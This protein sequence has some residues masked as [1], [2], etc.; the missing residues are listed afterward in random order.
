M[1]VASKPCDQPMADL[2]SNTVAS[3]SANVNCHSVCPS[4][5][6][7]RKNIVH[8]ITLNAPPDMTDEHK[9][10]PDSQPNSG[11]VT[12]CSCA[13]WSCTGQLQRR[14]VSRAD[15]I[16]QGLRAG[17][18]LAGKFRV[19][20]VIGRGGMG[21]IFAAHHMHLDQRVAIKVL[22]PNA[23]RNQEDIKHFFTEAQAAAKIK[24]ERAARV[25][26]LTVLDC[27]L[28]FLVMEYL[29]GCDLANWLVQKGPLPLALAVEFV[30]QAC[31]AIAEAHIAGIVHRDLKPGNMFCSQRPDGSW[32]IKVIDFGIAK[33]GPMSES[34]PCSHAMQHDSV[35]GSPHYMSPEQL[36]SPAE[37]DARADIW[38]LGVTLCE[39]LTGRLP[40]EGGALP[41]LAVNIATQPTPDMQEYRADIMSAIQPVIGRCLQKDPQLRYANVAELANALAPFAPNRAHLS[42]ERIRGSVFHGVATT[43]F[44]MPPIR[45]SV[46]KSTIR[47]RV[48]ASWCHAKRLTAGHQWASVAIILVLAAL[49]IALLNGRP[50]QSAASC[51]HVKLGC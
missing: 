4:S 19:E 13:E 6:T 28:M 48:Q 35:L 33:L 36:K 40:F 10:L 26:D 7:G 3:N 44:Q 37:V 29:E 43:K 41:E 32:A 17:S 39:L 1:I 21:L 34:D 23:L 46:R 9:P 18:V 45:T 12:Q 31:E 27:G 16:V 8:Q 5:G 11:C 14:A 49:G 22:R 47:R 24:S 42:L 15:S 2:N 20:K 30:L 50:R 25:L 38:S 51:A